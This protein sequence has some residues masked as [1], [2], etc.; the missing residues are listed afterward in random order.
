MPYTSAFAFSFVYPLNEKTP[1]FYRHIRQNHR[2]FSL[3]GGGIPLMGAS[4]YMKINLIFSINPRQRDPHTGKTMA[5]FHRGYAEPASAE[6]VLEMLKNDE[7]HQMVSRIR[8]GEEELKE[9]LPSICPHYSQFKNNHRAQADIIPEAFTYKTCVDVDEKDLVESAI[10]RSLEVNTDPFSDW[11]DMVEY[12][13]RSARNKLHIWIRIPRGMTIKEAQVAFCKEI[14]VPFDESCCTPERF[15]YMTGDEVY[16]SDNWLKPVSEVDLLYYKEDYLNRGLDVDG[17]PLVAT[18]ASTAVPAFIQEEI[19]SP[20]ILGIEVVEVNERTRFIMQECIK[21][22]GLEPKDFLIEGG[23]HNAVKAV[24]SVGAAQLLTKPEFFGVLSEVMP[25]HWQDKNITQLVNDFYSKYVEPSQRMT[26]FQ[27]RAFSESLKMVPFEETIPQEDES[28]KEEHSAIY[29]DTATLESI[30]RSATPP[31]LPKR[32][33]ALVKLVCSKTPFNMKATVAQAMFPALGA[34]PKGLS[35]NYIDNQK[36]ELRINCLTIGE[37]GSGKDT[38]LKNPLKFLTEPMMENSEKS[39]EKLNKW[40]Q[41]C[42]KKGGNQSKPERPSDVSIQFITGD[43]TQARLSQL[44]SDAK[45]AF[46]YTHLHEFE[47][48][49]SI[50]NC[51]GSPKSCTFTNLKLADDEDNI[52]GQERVGTESITYMGPLNLNWNASSTL[53][54]IQQIFQHVMVDGPISRLCLATTPNVEFGAPMP[55]YGKYDEK[56][57][58]ALKPYINNLE[59]ATGEQKCSPAN[60]MIER[61]KEECDTFSQ[62]SQDKVF[63]NLTH[64]ALVHVFRKACALYAANRFRWEKSIEGF[65]RW[66]LHYDLWLKLHFFGDFIR[67]A[68]NNTKTS[69][70]G[71]QNLLT[72]LPDEFTIQ[73]VLKVRESKGMGNDHKK[74]RSM[75]AQWKKRQYILQLTDDSFKKASAWKE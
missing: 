49:Y 14:N 40:V 64:R 7:L 45:G 16:R 21:E 73:D 9:Q 39:R 58:E 29:G 50:E 43:V 24:L 30:Y 74:A 67:E 31:L 22:T 36:R 47:Q 38:C 12:I 32:L 44:L 62:L 51:K 59:A 19:I 42:Q 23:R 63:N 66:S 27:R 35:F 54:R 41:E 69:K 70:T 28:K 13:E 56:Y 3:I 18:T 37:T 72:Y 68:N 26:Q 34:Y 53:T 52:F 11:A 25:E 61:L 65:C 57:R 4:I 60:R 15:I 17:R 10:K 5:K 2:L 71:P 1:F 55:K 20:D 33:P 46:L 75:L 6:R 8:N 48:W